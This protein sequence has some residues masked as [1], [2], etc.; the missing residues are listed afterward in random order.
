MRRSRCGARNAAGANGA[1][2]V[3]FIEVNILA[4]AQST[5]SVELQLVPYLLSAPDIRDGALARRAAAA[6]RGAFAC[7]PPRA[8]RYVRCDAMRCDAM[9]CDAAVSLPLEL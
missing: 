2:D 6:A 8:M 9:R 3:N 5:L 1:I 4:A 7:R